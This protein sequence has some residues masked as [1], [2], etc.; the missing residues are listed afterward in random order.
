[1]NKQIFSFLSALVL[2]PLTTI[3]SADHFSA[4]ISTYEKGEHEK[5]LM[6]FQAAL[7]TMEDAATHHNLALTYLKL[8]QPAYAIWQMEC[9]VRLDPRNESYNYKLSTMREQLGLFTA[10]MEWYQIATRLLLMDQWIILLSFSTWTWLALV[11]LPKIAGTSLSYSLKFCRILSF[12]LL[13][14]SLPPIIFLSQAHTY[15]IILSEI[16]V[17]VHAAP[18]GAAPTTGNARPG[19]RAKVIEQHDSYLK[20]KTE[21]QVIGWISQDLFSSIH[22]SKPDTRFKIKSNAL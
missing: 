19:E 20:I 15:G 21:G 11:I 6:Q 18:A 1:M 17:A 7:I 3:A 10:P 4:G 12:V 8:E 2:I 5:A 22:T 16:A 9:A 13:L 14:T